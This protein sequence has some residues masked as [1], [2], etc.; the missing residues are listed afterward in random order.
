MAVCGETDY[1]EDKRSSI[2]LEIEVRDK[3]Y[4]YNNHILNYGFELNKYTM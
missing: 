1:K 4:I 2:L 3:N